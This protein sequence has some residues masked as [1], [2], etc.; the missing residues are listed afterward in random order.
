VRCAVVAAEGEVVHERA[1]GVL[2]LEVAFRRHEL[3]QRLALLLD[4]R[5]VSVGRIGAGDRP[6]RPV[7]LF[8]VGCHGHLHLLRQDA[9]D[10]VFHVEVLVLDHDALVRQIAHP[11]LQTDRHTHA[12]ATRCWT[13]PA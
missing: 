5:D 13:T 7:G 11:A 10:G 3:Q 1:V 4:R 6:V 8:L 12:R 2:E 9:E